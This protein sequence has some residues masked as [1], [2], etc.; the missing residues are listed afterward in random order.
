MEKI[1]KI[2]YFY[3][4]GDILPY[5][6]YLTIFSFKKWNPEWRLI[7]YIP[8][9]PYQED[10][11]WGTPEHKNKSIHTTNY[12]PEVSRLGVEICPID[13][14]QIGFRN[15]VP[16]VF[17]SD[18]LRLWLLSTVGGLWSDMDI[19]F[20]SSLNS[21]SAGDSNT[22]LCYDRGIWRIGLM[23]SSPNNH[24][25]EIMY[26]QAHDNFNLENYQSMGTTLMKGISKNLDCANL[27]HQDLNVYGLSPSVVYPISSTDAERIYSSVERN[28]ATKDTIGLHWYGG[29]PKAG[30]AISLIDSPSKIVGSTIL[31]QSIGRALG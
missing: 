9:S 31:Y 17:K 20:F 22:V 30:P 3:W 11:T 15:D 19:L 2:A 10:L 5:L 18:F 23:M 4:G 21:I 16:E 12:M 8:S 26:K 14:S 27:L 6:R 25:F 24:F 13:L 28:W 1:P 7:L 29:Y